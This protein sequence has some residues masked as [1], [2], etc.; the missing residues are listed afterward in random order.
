MV[1]KNII[2]G[3][4]N[5]FIS[6][7]PVMV[8]LIVLFTFD[9]IIKFYIKN[10]EMCDNITRIIAFTFVTIISIY[11]IKILIKRWFYPPQN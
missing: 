7:I 6:K 9:K 1:N 4:I 2:K 5:I 11:S 10:T 3:D 8:F